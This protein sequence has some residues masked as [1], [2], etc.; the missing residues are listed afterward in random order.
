MR[1]RINLTADAAFPATPSLGHAG[2]DQGTRGAFAASTFLP[3]IDFLEL[4][5]VGFRARFTNG[6]APGF[7]LIR[8]EPTLHR[9]QLEFDDANAGS[10]AIGAYW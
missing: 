9:V 7:G 5:H 3:G 1:P 6:Q 10:V 4:S 8:V 2:A